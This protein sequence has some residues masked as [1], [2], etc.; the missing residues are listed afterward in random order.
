MKLLTYIQT[1]F[2]FLFVFLFFGT[3]STAQSQDKE[4][5]LDIINMEKNSFYEIQ[6]KANRYFSKEEKPD[7]KEARSVHYESNIAAVNNSTVLSSINT[8]I[9]KK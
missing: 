7:R 4:E 8:F 1:H 3:L 5:V 9:I 2:V 6:R